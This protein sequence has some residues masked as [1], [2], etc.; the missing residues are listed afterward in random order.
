[1]RNMFLLYDE[2]YDYRDI[3]STKNLSLEY[4]FE[5]LMSQEHDS[6]IK[7]EEDK[8]DPNKVIIWS[9]LNIKK[10]LKLKDFSIDEEFWAYVDRYHQYSRK[11]LAEMPAI[12]ISRKNYE[13]LEKQWQE[14]RKNKPKYLIFREHDNGYVDILEKDELSAEDIA[15]MNR[16]HK[17]YQNY[18]K[19]WNEYK[20]AHPEK[21]YPIWRSP[22]DN[23]FESDFALYDPVDEQGC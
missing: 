1:M 12:R 7:F 15:T 5:Y 2:K 14:I 20:K 17:I 23:F 8:N 11:R 21:L 9:T 19:R 10:P 4:L 6:F 22:A 3:V 16:E 13:E 18:I